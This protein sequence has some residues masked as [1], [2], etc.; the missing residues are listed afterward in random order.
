MSAVSAGEAVVP[1]SELNDALKQILELWP[2]VLAIYLFM[3]GSV[4]PK[5]VGQFRI[6]AN[7]RQK[8]APVPGARR[9]CLPTTNGL[10]RP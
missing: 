10:Q 5:Q 1:A 8:K 2:S 9:G 4:L 3:P 7:I 6:R